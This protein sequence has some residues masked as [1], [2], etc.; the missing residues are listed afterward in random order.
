MILRKKTQVYFLREK[1]KAFTKFKEFKAPVEK[2]SDFYVKT[3][4]SNRGG[5]FT[6]NEFFNFCKNQGIQCQLIA[7]Y[8]PQQNGISERKNR[9][10]FEMVRSLLKAKSLLKHFLAEIVACVVFLLNRCPTKSVFGKTPEEAWRGNKP[11]VS[12]FHVFGCITYSHILD[13][14][15]KKLDD[16]SQKCIF[17]GYSE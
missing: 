9:T 14:R 7:S 5:E 6:L 13:E 1:S 16:K 15:R 12:F 10:I 2:Q 3:L 17:I 11:N 8:T 4:Q